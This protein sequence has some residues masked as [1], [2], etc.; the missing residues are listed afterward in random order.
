MP[1]NRTSKVFQAE[2]FEERFM[3]TGHLVD[4]GRVILKQYD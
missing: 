2:H 4:T 1:A 3:E